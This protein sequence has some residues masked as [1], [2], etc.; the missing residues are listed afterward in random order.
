LTITWSFTPSAAFVSGTK[1]NVYMKALDFSNSTVGWTD[2]GDWTVF[3]NVAPTL[4]TVSPAS[5]TSGTGSPQSLTAVYSDANGS[6]DVSLA[7]LMVN[8][9]VNGANG[10]Y[11]YYAR[12]TGR[13]YLQND[14]GS[15]PVGNCLPGSATTLSNSQGTIDCAAT[16]VTGLGNDLTIVWRVTPIGTFTG[17]KNVYLNVKDN[18]GAIPGWADRGDWTITP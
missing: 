13:L 18:A 7:Y 3:T 15:G 8:A 16:T 11:A 2:K 17:A 10:I 6:G 9:T 5:L 4:G 14:A 1:K 12:S